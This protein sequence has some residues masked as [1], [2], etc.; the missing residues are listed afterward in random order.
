MALG[1]FSENKLVYV[2]SFIGIGFVVAWYGVS[3]Y[4]GLNALRYPDESA[5]ALY[6]LNY[7]GTVVYVTFYQYLLTYGLPACGFLIL[8]LLLFI[9]RNDKS[10]NN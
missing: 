9:T 6:S 5:G 4:W 3:E 10:N 1:K 8:L 2:L 7:H